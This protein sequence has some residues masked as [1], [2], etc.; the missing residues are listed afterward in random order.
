MQH[1][2]SKIVRLDKGDEYYDRY[3]ESGKYTDNFDKYFE[4]CGII[5]Q[6]TLTG[7]LEHNGLAER[8]NYTLRDKEKSMMSQPKLHD[9]LWGETLNAFMH[10]LNR[11]PSKII[12]KTP[13]KLFK[14]W[15]PDLDTLYVMGCVVELTFMTSLHKS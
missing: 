9:F 15:K 13:F 7:T 1:K 2:Y 4:E 12:P 11:V 3:G 14:Y 6:Y 10:I 8:R 5:F